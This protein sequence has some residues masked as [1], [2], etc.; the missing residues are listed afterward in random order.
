VSGG[1]GGMVKW[2]IWAVA[3]LV[4]VAVI[5]AGILAATA[6]KTLDRKAAQDGISK[7]LTDKYSIQ[8]VGNVS[9]PSSIKVKTGSTFTCQ[10]SING[11]QKNVTAKFTDDK[12]TY[13]VGQPQ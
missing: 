8:G 5:V 12:G 4:V 1:R 2:A 7:V 13:E 6:S 10:V 3:G 9:C 11:E